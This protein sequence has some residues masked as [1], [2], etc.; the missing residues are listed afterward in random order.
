[1]ALKPRTIHAFTYSV[2]GMDSFH[3]KLRKSIMKTEGTCVGCGEKCTLT[4]GKAHLIKCAGILKTLHSHAKIDEGC[5]ARVSWTEQQ[6]TYW[7]F[8]AIPKKLSIGDLDEFLRDTWLECCC[9]LSEFKIS[10]QAYESHT[11]SGSP[12]ASMKKQTGQIFSP[13]LE[14]KYVYDMGSS[15]ELI[16]QV[17]EPLEVCPSKKVTVLVQNDPPA[18]PC[19]MCKKMAQIVCSL[20]GEKV[21]RKCGSRHACA[22]QEEDTYM[23]LPLV[24]SP[25]TGVCGY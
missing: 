1:M 18:F 23:L 4:N 10:G 22:V 24:N 20:C 3:V 21:C 17:L 16:L 7:M 14:F 6:N 11:E 5:L 19:R 2:G 13:G 12:S 25:R 9:H 8:I 15:T